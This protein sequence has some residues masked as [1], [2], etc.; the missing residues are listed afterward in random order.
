MTRRLQ[1]RAHL[2]PVFQV[3]VLARKE[4]MMALILKSVCAQGLVGNWEAVQLLINL[5]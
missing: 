5:C 3:M 4:E 2:N 1:G